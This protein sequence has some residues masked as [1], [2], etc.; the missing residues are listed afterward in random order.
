[1]SAVATTEGQIEVR[2]SER[3][4]L[5][6]GK[7]GYEIRLEGTVVGYTF[8]TTRAKV[9]KGQTKVF[10][11]AQH[12]KVRKTAA[13]RTDAVEAAMPGHKLRW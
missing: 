8:A 7:V 9:R 5:K 4:T 3:K 13:K 10:W 1:M 12:G 2:L 6:N 11:T